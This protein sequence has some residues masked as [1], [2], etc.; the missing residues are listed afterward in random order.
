[1][2]SAAAGGMRLSN[3]SYGFT[4]GILRTL[5]IF[6]LLEFFV[7]LLGA[8]V[9]VAGMLMRPAAAELPPPIPESAKPEAM[10]GAQK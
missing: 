5:V 7:I 8:G 4:S 3:H 6:G 1:M 9:W 10:A 2:A